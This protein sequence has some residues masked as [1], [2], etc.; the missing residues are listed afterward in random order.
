MS[1]YESQKSQTQADDGTGITSTIV[2]AKKALDVNVAG[3]T[4]VV[5][6]LPASGLSRSDTYA[7][8]GTGATVDASSFIAQSYLLQVKGTGAAATSWVVVIEG[9][10]DSV[11]FTTLMTHATSVG[12]GIAL[13]SGANLYPMLYFRSRVVSLVLGPATSIVVT[14]AG[15]G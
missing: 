9:S 8:P 1:S 6:T 12:D 11:N 5:S 7:A 2:G 14:I 4:V 15:K 10:P 13:L 3:G